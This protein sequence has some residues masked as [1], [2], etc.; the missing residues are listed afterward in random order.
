M[1][2]IRY[3]GALRIRVT[4]T[5]DWTKGPAEYRCHIS[6]PSVRGRAPVTI[7]VH[8]K[9]FETHARDSSVAFD[10]IAHA[11]LTFAANEGWPIESYAQGDTG[12]WAIQRKPSRHYLTR[13]SQ[14]ELC[15]AEM[16]RLDATIRA[17]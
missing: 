15:A 13:L 5:E 7:Y 8:P 11:A 2:A 12:G 10:E 16:R 4:Y 14:S 9:T 6:C 1:S 3:S 17:K